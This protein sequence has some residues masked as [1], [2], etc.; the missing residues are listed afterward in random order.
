MSGEV[1]GEVVGAVALGGGEGGVEEAKQVLEDWV[2]RVE[3]G[4]DEEKHVE[5]REAAVAA[6]CRFVCAGEHCARTWRAVV[7]VCVSRLGAVSVLGVS[8]RPGV[9]KS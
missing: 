1:A 2:T 3:E 6:V 9:E 8:S 5:E 7:F 4:A